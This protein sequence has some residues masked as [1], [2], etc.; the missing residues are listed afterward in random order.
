MKVSLFNL[1][2]IAAKSLG[3]SLDHT[4]QCTYSDVVSFFRNT[5]VYSDHLSF[6]L[7]NGLFWNAFDITKSS[8]DGHC[9]LHSIT[10]C[11]VNHGWSISKGDICQS[12]EFEIFDNTNAY[13]PFMGEDSSLLLFQLLYAYTLDKHYDSEFGDLVPQICANALNV[14]INIVSLHDNGHLFFRIQPYACES[15]VEI[16]VY[17][18]GPH[19][20]GL[21]PSVVCRESGAFAVQTE[22]PCN[23]RCTDEELRNDIQVPVSPTRADSQPRPKICDSTHVTDQ[24]TLSDSFDIFST[25]DGSRISPISLTSFGICFH[26]IHGLTLEKISD[27]MLGSFFKKFNLVLLCE[28]WL[29][30]SQTDEFDILDNYVFHNFSRTRKHPNAIRDSGGL[31]VYVHKS[32]EH[33]IDFTS[34]I[35]DIISTMK[36]KKRCI[37]STYG[38]ICL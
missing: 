10:S 13:L 20:D 35:D 27:D 3:P 24:N 25:E 15:S 2:C 16:F 30:K 21:L 28:T 12:I 37:W 8:P 19:Y 11:L 14:N 4:L 32:F 36:L 22:R 5:D 38:H 34:R 6:V 18:S 23:E 26:N 33:G 1:N 7:N 29:D 9:F 31:G 17:K